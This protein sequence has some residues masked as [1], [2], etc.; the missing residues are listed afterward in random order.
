[1]NK[2]TILEKILDRQLVWISRADS[3]ISLILPLATAMLG[4]LVALTPKPSEWTILPAIL[5]TISVILILLAIIFSALACFPRTDG[6][7]SSNIFFNGIA[8]RE[9]EQYK[10]AIDELSEDYYLEDLSR[11]C[12]RNAQIAKTKTGWIQKA[13]ASLLI[14]VV[15]WVVTLHL[16]YNGK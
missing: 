13:L 1:M 8:D 9:A 10:K 4:A 3:R 6:P 11:Q 14:S 2:I 7:K 16:L 15:P 5:A 12:H